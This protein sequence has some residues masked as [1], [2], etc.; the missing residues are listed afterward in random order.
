LAKWLN[1]SDAGDQAKSR[2]SSRLVDRTSGSVFA[3]ALARY[4][5]TWVTSVRLR[6]AD[7]DEER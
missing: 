5:D 1:Q 6:A 4:D 7:D 3:V 2:V